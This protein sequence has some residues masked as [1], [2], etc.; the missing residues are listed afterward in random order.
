MIEPRA[1]RHHWSIAATAAVIVVAG[2]A[3]GCGQGAFIT[4]GLSYCLNG[5]VLDDPGSRF[6]A[7][8]EQVMRLCAYGVTLP[9]VAAPFLVVAARTAH[10][11]WIAVALAAAVATGM[12]LFVFDYT[13]SN[14][15]EFHAKAGGV[16]EQVSQRCPGYRPPW[17]PF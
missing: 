5:R 2:C 14:D 8:V 7:A 6:A 4:K 16:V 10:R 15:I 9:V 11:R 3:L 12:A 1:R 13:R 17:W